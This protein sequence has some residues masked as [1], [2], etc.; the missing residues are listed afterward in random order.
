MRKLPI[1]LFVIGT[2]IQL[3]AI[4]GEHAV[5]IPFVIRNIAPA[6]AHASK[7]METLVHGDHLKHGDEGFTEVA[8]V[9]LDNF[10]QK[11]NV[12]TN[13]T[14][15]SIDDIWFDPTAMQAGESVDSFALVDFHVATVTTQIVGEGGHT[16]L[17]HLLNLKSAIDELKTPSL[18][19]FCFGM[20]FIGVIIDAVAFF[21]ESRESHESGDHQKDNK[22]DETPKPSSE[23][24]H[25]D[26][27]IKCD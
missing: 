15:L 11:H 16:G 3:A 1:I 5:E 14:D 6:Y 27:S 22:N 9:L 18:L 8:A 21:L 7:G 26:P 23:T 20:F 19:R 25:E 13:Y 24:N 12:S 2:T 10:K 4:F 17:I